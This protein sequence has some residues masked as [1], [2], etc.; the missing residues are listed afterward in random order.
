MAH[1]TLD[2][3]KKAVEKVRDDAQDAGMHVDSHGRCTMDLDRVAAQKGE[4]VADRYRKDAAS[5]TKV[6]RHWTDAIKKAVKDAQAAD[7][8]MKTAFMAEPK[9]SEKGLPN[10]FDGSIGDDAVK[11][12]A[13]R[14]AK[15]YKSILDG[16][17]PSSEKLREASVL[18][19]GQSDDPEFSRTLL[20]SVGGPEGVIKIQNRLDDL[21][22]YDDKG[23]KKSY[24]ALRDGLATNLA[25]ATSKD[26][27]DAKAPPG[28][29]RAFID[30][31]LSELRSDGLKKYDLELASKK[32]GGQKIRGYQA[33]ASLME[34]SDRKYGIHFLHGLADDI[35]AAEDPKNDGDPGDPDIWDLEG[36]F[37]GEKGKKSGLFDH[38]GSGR[39]ANDPL[40]GVLDVMSRN[41]KA[42]TDYLD[43][44]TKEGE[45]R[46]NYLKNERDW[47]LVNNKVSHVS[48]TGQ[49]Q[50]I[51]AHDTEDKDARSGY[52]ALL[53]AAMTGDASGAAKPDDFGK[54]SEAEAQ[55]FEKVVKSYGADAGRDLSSIPEGIRQNL[56]N[57]VA[58]YPQDVRDI[59]G[60][61]ADYTQ[62]S[63][64]TDANDLKIS[65][66]TMHLFLRG[67]SEDGG[68]FRTIHDSQISEIAKSISNLN[69]EDFHNYHGSDD[70]DV[71]RESAKTMGALDRIRA[72][73][74]G[75]ER[76]AEI[77]RNNWS[78]TYQYHLIG[79]PLTGIP[80]VGDSAQ[81][82]VDIV[83]GKHAESLNDAAGDKTRQ[84]L[85]D[86][87]SEKGYPRLQ[88]L[89]TRRAIDVGISENEIKDSGSGMGDL[90]GDAQD[91]YGTGI[92]NS[93]SSTGGTD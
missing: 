31:W 42:A 48:G 57:T 24:L 67:V 81:R 43:P 29:A 88:Q 89:L 33:L 53:E 10:G 49:V 6:E 11:A 71:V 26:G 8:A 75:S 2:A 3:H 39:F 19:R 23:N 55:L 25:T 30:K 21:A 14:A 4:D 50:I 15:T 60:G 37:S 46:F 5:R 51:S 17:T 72:D 82:L 79:T 1:A 27:V 45:D 77:D 73:V 40:D 7:S 22:Y 70:K 54:H 66:P 74:L 62:L 20:N 32:G 61:S 35:R 68:A 92:T 76:D 13:K 52:G 38:S 85:I 93:K 9:E 47:D 64:G 80:Y 56:A 90:L 78:K 58:S 87:Y 69:N 65:N 36:D 86:F 34:H 44:Q 16:K 18:V 41:P 63:T 59:I 12:N 28:A 84:E 83:A 91:W